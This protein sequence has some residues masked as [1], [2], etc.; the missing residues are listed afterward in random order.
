MENEITQD[1]Q[2]SR[3]APVESDDDM[4]GHDTNTPPAPATHEGESHKTDAGGGYHS[5]DKQQLKPPQNLRL[6]QRDKSQIKIEWDIDS[7]I[8][9]SDKNRWHYT[10]TYKEFNEDEKENNND[11]NDNRTPKRLG[12][13]TVKNGKMKCKFS[14][15]SPNE[16]YYFAVNISDTKQ[17]YDSSHYSETLIVG[18]YGVYEHCAI[19]FFF[20][21]VHPCTPVLLL[22]RFCCCDLDCSS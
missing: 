18:K 5:I 6:L 2:I 17:E 8:S 22:K 1:P 19:F 7:S 9:Q 3:P 12:S 16:K 4:L 21:F 14:K 15:M 13:T 20:L 11:D 10:V